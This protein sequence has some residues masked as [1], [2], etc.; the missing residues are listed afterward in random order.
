MNI[1]DNKIQGELKETNKDKTFMYY[2]SIDGLRALSCLGII[3]MHIQANTEYQLSGSFIFERVIPS[4]TWLVYLFLMI[5]GFGM[6][7]GYL[8]KFQNERVDLNAFYKKRY[9][10]ILPFFGMLLAIAL[11]VDHN[12]STV[13]E[14]SI[15]VLLL[16]GLLPNNEVSVIGVCW[17][18]GVI[19]LFYLLFPAFSVL[20]KSKKRAWGSLAVSLWIVFVCEHYFFSDYFV[21]KSF[22]PRHNFLYCLPMFIVGGLVYLYRDE[23]KSICGKY[24]LLVLAV[25]IAVSVAWYFIICEFE[26]IFYIGTLGLFGLWLIYAIGSNSNLLSSK[27]MRFLSGISM[28]MYLAQMVIFRVVKKLDM[29]YIFG[30]TGIGGWFSFLLA[31]VLTVFGLICFIEGYKFVIGILKRKNQDKHKAMPLS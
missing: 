31:F 20:M 17:T 13:Y 7:V 4:L 29:L 14:I 26:N 10:K 22:T 3:L 9:M 30:N 15:E 8:N 12:I 1:S 28:E 21:T 5:S 27:P 16:H 18:L 19:F 11:V 6:C 24:R 2:K 23:I 25:C